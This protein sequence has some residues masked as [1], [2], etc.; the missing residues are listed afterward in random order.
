MVE[1]IARWN[2]SKEKRNPLQNCP[3]GSAH[4]ILSRIA[5]GVH[6]K[7]WR[8]AKTRRARTRSSRRAGVSKKRGR[9]AFN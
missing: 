6:P 5:L 8:G 4:L 2:A 7:L 1:R 3:V 9:L